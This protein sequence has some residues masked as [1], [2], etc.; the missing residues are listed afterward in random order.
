VILEASEEVKMESYET[1]ASVVTAGSV[2]LLL[3]AA[4][5]AKKQLEAAPGTESAPQAIARSRS[6]WPVGKPRRRSDRMIGTAMDRTTG[7]VA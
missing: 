3:I 1:Y 2:A 4:G 7:G 5:V 6:R